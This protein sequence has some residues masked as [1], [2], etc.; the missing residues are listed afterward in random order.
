MT[1]LK[2]FS[3]LSDTLYEGTSDF[4]GA[5][6]SLLV[7]W[8]CQGTLQDALVAWTMI[9]PDLGMIQLIQ[10][11]RRT[12]LACCLATNQEPHRASYMS[13][14]LGYCGLF[15]RE[16]YSC[17]IGIAKP[18]AAY[19]RSI[20]D[21]LSLSSTNV[22]F[23]DDREDNV[24]AARDVGLNATQFL[25]DDGPLNLVQTLATFGIHLDQRTVSGRG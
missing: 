10:Q 22:L 20:L 23:L 5:F 6:S 15:D 24:I 7:D 3:K 2:R 19:F 11:L 17:R 1:L 14:R 12:G 13:E 4:I 25:I 21:D 18:A 16:F 8:P 9:E